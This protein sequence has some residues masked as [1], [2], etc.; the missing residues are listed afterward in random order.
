MRLGFP[1]Y[2]RHDAIN[3]RAYSLLA[4]NVYAAMLF[5]DA[6]ILVTLSIEAIW[7]C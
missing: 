5:T 1:N 7:L 2:T 6:Q 3:K 4:A